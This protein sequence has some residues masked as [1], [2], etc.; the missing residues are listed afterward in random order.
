MDRKASTLRA[1]S[2]YENKREADRISGAG[3]EEAAAALTPKKPRRAK[4]SDP[5]AWTEH[6]VQCSIAVVLNRLGLLWCHVPNEGKRSVVAGS[7][8]RAAGLKSGV[9]DILIFSSA[10]N[11]PEA[12][13]VAIELKRKKGGRLSETQ[14]DWLRR[15]ED[16]G[17]YAVVCHGYDE[18]MDEIKKLGYIK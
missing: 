17:W 3:D 13:G 9:P 12:H 8:L 5:N 1:L 10:P 16:A 4:S 18:T 6:Q 14:K 7:R 15:L 11:K 2:R